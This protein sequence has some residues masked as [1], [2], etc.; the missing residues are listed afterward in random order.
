MQRI[1][2]FVVKMLDRVQIRLTRARPGSVLILVVVLVVLLALLGTATL[3]T[4]QGDRWIA[5]QNSANTQVDLIVQGVIEMAKATIIGDLFGTQNNTT[6]FRPADRVDSTSDYDDVDFPDLT[7]PPTA[8]PIQND[9]WLSHRAPNVYSVNGNVPAPMWPSLGRLQ[10]IS[11]FDTPVTTTARAPI[12]GLSLADLQIPT[13]Y[14]DRISELAGAGGNVTLMPNY[15]QPFGASGPSYPAFNVSNTVPGGRFVVAGDAD[16]DGA[17]DSALFKVPVGEVDGVTYYAAVRIIDN[18]SAINLNTA[19]S[20]T[21]DFRSTDGAA[22]DALGYNL[23]SPTTDNNLGMFRAHVGLREL[24]FKPTSEMPAI[25]LYRRNNQPLSA[26]P[27]G[28][29]GSSTRTDYSY[30]T[31]GEAMETQFARKLEYPGYAGPG[32]HYQRM[33]DTEGTSLAYRSML[34]NREAGPTALETRLINAVGSGQVDTLYYGASNSDMNLNAGTP[35]FQSNKI[36]YLASPR[37][38]GAWFSDNFHFE[39]FT[40][41]SAS[42]PGGGS[43]PLNTH[44]SVPGYKPSVRALLTTENPVSNQIR[45]RTTGVP[46]SAVLPSVGTFGS[47]TPTGPARLLYAGAQ[48]KFAYMTP[49]GLNPVKTNVNTAGFDELWR[50][51]W[52]VMMENYP[53]GTPF[54]GVATDNSDSTLGMHFATLPSDGTDGNPKFA[55]IVGSSHPQR[56]FRSSMRSPVGSGKYFTPQDM[57][58]LRS[59]MAAVQT[60]QLR[61]PDG[62]D[63]SNPVE[64]PVVYE[65]IH[66]LLQGK[67]PGY[68]AR[69]T[70]FGASPQ[71]FITEIFAWRDIKTKDEVGGGDANMVPYVAIE[72][73]NPYPV[74]I[75]LTDKF[76]IAT[77]DRDNP[78]N[79]PGTGMTPSDLYT[80]SGTVIQPNEFLLIDNANELT[81]VPPSAQIA[82]NLNSS[83]RISVLGLNALI[84]SNKEL[85]IYQEIPDQDNPGMT[86]KKAIDSFDFF[87]FDPGGNLMNSWHYARPCGNDVRWQCVYPGRYWARAATGAESQRHQGTDHKEW[88]PDDNLGNTINKDPGMEAPYLP[89]LGRAS[90][91]DASGVLHAGQFKAT[92]PAALPI[93]LSNLGFGG[94]NKTLNNAGNM[95]PFG[96]FMRNGDILQVPYIAAYTVTLHPVGNLGGPG[97]LLDMNSVSMDSAFAEDSDPQNDYPTYPSALPEVDVNQPREQVGRFCPI[98]IGSSVSPT[99]DDFGT[100]INL[101]RYAW[102]KDLFDYLTVTTPSRDYLPEYPAQREWVDLGGQ[103]REFS[104]GSLYSVFAGTDHAIYRCNVSGPSNAG[105]TPDPG[106]FTLLATA[107]SVDNIKQGSASQV[108]MDG[109]SDERE[110]TVAIQGLINLN[111]APWKVLAAVPWVPAGSD[112]FQFANPSASEWTFTVGS[113]GR[114]DN[115][116]IARA[117]VYWRDGDYYYSNF[118]ARGPF[119]SIFDLY[120]VRVPPDPATPGQYVFELVQNTLSSTGEPD[121]AQGDFSPYNQAVPPPSDTKDHSRYDFEEQYLLMTKVSNLLTTRS[122]SFTVYIQVQGWR[123]IGTLKPE[124]VVQRRASFMMDRS[125]ITATSTP[126]NAT[127]FSNE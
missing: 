117:I 35:V 82:A 18:G 61:G 5:T 8:M 97:I 3:S 57:V 6:L 34:Q 68:E 50:A 21:S 112:R 54:N 90:G 108:T 7:R 23:G 44:P 60:M 32:A 79:S 53:T 24:L 78:Y 118:T 123:G 113:N 106:T 98:R 71:P 101:Y 45:P 48:P 40:G 16:A 36:A 75:T 80:F 17:A 38:I 122:D 67:F 110:N 59:A 56:M 12:G 28:D 83:N 66:G 120:K 37:G 65:R 19:G 119:R 47:A 94:P 20:Q 41:A 15:M 11:K 33:G 62:T 107:K 74:P 39:G 27:I 70:V 111:T 109:A 115:E 116:D 4:T 102:A 81:W 43:A 127:P 105:T 52:C 73:Y 9:S 55:A 13:I 69:V 72:L 103:P 91:T 96:G 89:T 95:Y 42:L 64:Q 84:G 114:D 76:K 63:P 49:Y 1:T 29:D 2:H 99:I 88:N 31:L 121:D 46:G 92:I 10:G 14:T 125:K 25:D 100:D 77:V 30:L 126:P 93:Q 104:K 86:L 51:Y 87:G 124:L 58:L 22:V 26:T 85:I